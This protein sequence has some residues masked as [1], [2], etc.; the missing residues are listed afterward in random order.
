MPEQNP[1]RCRQ[2]AYSSAFVWAEGFAAGEA[3]AYPFPPCS[4]CAA[5]II[6]SGIMAVVA[7][8]P[9]QAQL[10]RWGDSMNTATDMFDEAGV[11]LELMEFDRWGDSSPSLVGRRTS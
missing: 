1:Y 7:P 8:T 6:Q 9:T 2:A 11:R 3:A 10:D 4:A 5:L